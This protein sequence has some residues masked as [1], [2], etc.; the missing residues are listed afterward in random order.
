[1]NKNDD[2]PKKKERK[3]TKTKHNVNRMGEKTSEPAYNSF[4][5]NF[6]INDL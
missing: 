3:K 4:D 1:M 2:K 5:F 6:R